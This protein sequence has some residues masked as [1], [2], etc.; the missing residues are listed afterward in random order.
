MAGSFD[1]TAGLT[2]SSMSKLLAAKENTTVAPGGQTG[3]NA[4]KGAHYNSGSQQNQ[5]N[6]DSRDRPQKNTPL[7]VLGQAQGAEQK[8]SLIQGRGM[9]YNQQLY[10]NQLSQ[11]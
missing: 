10:L 11:S 1:A 4:Y 6:H 2:Q 8:R 7:G 9:V 3:K 5:F